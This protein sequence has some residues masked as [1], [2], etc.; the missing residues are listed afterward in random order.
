MI[1]HPVTPSKPLIHTACGRTAH[2]V[3]ARG[4]VQV[5]HRLFGKPAR[6]FHVECACC[7]VATR[8]VYSKRVAEW[9]WQGKPE[10]LVALASLPAL[11]IAAERSLLAA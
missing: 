7:G 10:G 2:L 5:D 1:M 3:E 4:R 9:M 6:Q 8:P 11:R